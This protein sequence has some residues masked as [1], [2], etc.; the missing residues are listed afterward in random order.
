MIFLVRVQLFR[1]FSTIRVFTDLIKSLRLWTISY[2]VSLQYT[3]PWVNPPPPRDPTPDAHSQVLIFTHAPS[4]LGY[5]KLPSGVT[6][7]MLRFCDRAIKPRIE[8]MAKPA[9]KLV[10]QLMVLVNNASLR[11]EQ[12]TRDNNKKE[13]ISMIF[14]EPYTKTIIHSICL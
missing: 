14:H 12:K 5:L 4:K 10:K 13:I 9:K 7:S 8:K 1:L 2:P 3:F 6:S 11:I